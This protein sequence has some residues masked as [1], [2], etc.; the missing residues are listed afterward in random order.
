MSKK[1]THYVSETLGT[2]AP[3]GHK[4]EIDPRII[5]RMRDGDPEAYSI[6]YL[7]YIGPLVDF[8][9][10][11]L[12]CKSDAEEI[13][14]DVFMQIWENREKID[15]EKNIRG[16]IYKFA[17]FGALNRLAHKK[18]EDKYIHIQQHQ[19][20]IFDL[21]A[22]DIVA[23]KEMRL[24]IRITLE[25]MPEQRRKVFEMNRFEGMS[26]EQIA[27]ALHINK[28]TVHA[29]LYNAVKD[30]RE[31]IGLLLLFLAA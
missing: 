29:H 12:R 13:A 25:R 7:H 9:S 22:D 18:V 5:R 3:P 26:I 2:G 24:I 28:K 1:T 15:P 27:D 23:E 17:K 11:L 4:K 16:F 10:A 20:D 6:I 21:A 30:L 14:Q 19:A 31:V 8:L